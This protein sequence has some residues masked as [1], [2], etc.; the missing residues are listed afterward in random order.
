[1]QNAYSMS[2]LVTYEPFVDECANIFSTRMDEVANTD[3]AV[4]MGHWLQCYAFDVIGYMT[5]SKRLGFLDHGEDVENVIAALEDHLVYAT[6][7]G[8]FPKIHRLLF[9]LRN[10]L[11]GGG[12]KGRAYVIKFTKERIA[13]HEKRVESLKVSTNENTEL[14]D[15]LSKFYYKHAADPNVF[16][17]F[18]LLT[19][20]ATNM[21]AG[22]DTT[23]VSLSAILYYLL[24]FPESLQRLREEVS[25]VRAL[26]GN[27][28]I[29]FQES[30]EMP[31]LQAVIKEGLRMHSAT[32]LPLERVV[33][34]GGATIC[35][36]YFPAGV[37]NPTATK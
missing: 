17:N 20:C 22:S 12:A 9:H 1:M 14:L 27:R 23:A 33:P 26:S 30:L 6:L 3:L 13:E 35:D 18:H 15:F 7:T 2:S 25:N 16:T 24:K 19:G 8:I 10:S 37:N 31:Y 36:Q 5:F 4:D 32:G 29:S 21:V 34:D 28:K 11:S